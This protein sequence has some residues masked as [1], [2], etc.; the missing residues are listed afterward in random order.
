MPN[1]QAIFPQYDAASRLRWL[2]GRDCAG[3]VQASR[4]A[5]VLP[6]LAEVQQAVEGGLYA[7][8]YVAY[9]AAGGIDE[10]FETHSRES[11]I[12]NRDSGME[13]ILRCGPNP[14]SRIPNPDLPLVWFGLFKEMAVRDDP[15]F[16]AG[17]EFA[18]GDWQPSV[19][20][21]EYRQAIERIKAYIAAGDTYQVNYT[22][23]LRAECREEGF[24]GES[25]ETKT[26]QRHGQD[27]HATHGRDARA[28]H[29]QDAHATL[30]LRL[31]R[32]QRARYAAYI[33]A[34]DF[35]ICSAS[36]ELFFDLSD[37]VLTSKPMKGTAPRGATPAEDQAL[38]KALAASAKN[39]AENAMIVDMMRN[40]LGRIAQVGSVAVSDVFAIEEYPTLFQ[41]TSTVT[42]R[43]SAPFV[44]IIRALFPCASITGA[45]KVRT[46]QIIRE[47]EPDQRGVYTGCIGYLAPGGRARFNVAIRTVAIDRRTGQAQYGTGGGIVWDS[48][49]DDEYAEAITKAA[50]LRCMDDTPSPPANQ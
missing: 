6:A 13:N 11:G 4:P 28:T 42:A 14:E 47:L 17:G 36:P 45:P 40:D 5:D 50:V 26:R 24:A 35:A 30:F 44:E 21:E 15:P 20:R 2:C 32:A 18:L 37:G 33:E 3:A 49:P 23:R 38:R 27:A 34:D 16:A 41:M 46:M 12:G 31:C 1:V 48:Q 9:E 22:F 43:T 7:A 19:S 10:H 29:G 39:Q 8:G 25:Q